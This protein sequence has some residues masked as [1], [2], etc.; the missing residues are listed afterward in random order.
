MRIMIAFQE[1]ELFKSIKDLGTLGAVGLA[2]WF[3][4]KALR[5][6][7]ADARGEREAAEQRYAKREEARDAQFLSAL[8]AERQQGIDVARELGT[9]LRTS[10]EKVGQDQTSALRDLSSRITTQV[11]P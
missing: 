2:A 6:A 11:R 9:E 4:W 10:I 3:V 7:Q 5:D 1:L 8:A